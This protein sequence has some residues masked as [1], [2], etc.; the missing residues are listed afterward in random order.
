MKS[1]VIV[2]TQH[3]ALLAGRCEGRVYPV[4]TCMSRSLY[5][6]VSAHVAE[7]HKGHERC[8]VLSALDAEHAH[9]Q[10]A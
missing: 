7:R 6:R 10:D 5:G 9:A 8:S 3:R 4:R 2:A 1:A